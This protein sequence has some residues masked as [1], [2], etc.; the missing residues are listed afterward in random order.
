[1]VRYRT[2]QLRCEQAFHHVGVSP[3][4][5]LHERGIPEPESLL[6]W[7]RLAREEELHAREMASAACLEQRGSTPGVALVYH[8]LRSEVNNFE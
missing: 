1:M 2:F 4:S 3:R 8:R 7:L 6:V 5:R